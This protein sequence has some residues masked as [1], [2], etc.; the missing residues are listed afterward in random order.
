MTRPTKIYVVAGASGPLAA[1]TVK[2]ELHRWLKKYGHR[3]HVIHS[4][5]DGPN[6]NLTTYWD[7][8]GEQIHTRDEFAEYQARSAKDVPSS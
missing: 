7:G 3:G 6:P 5:P 8:Q 2:H 1:F 4:M